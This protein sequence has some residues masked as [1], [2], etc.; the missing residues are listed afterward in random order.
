MINTNLLGAL[1]PGLA[2]FTR[3]IVLSSVVGCNLGESAVVRRS[4]DV[5][6][7]AGGSTGQDALGADLPEP[8]AALLNVATF[9][10][11]RGSGD[12]PEIDGKGVESGMETGMETGSTAADATDFRSDSRFDAVGVF[13][14]A[15]SDADEPCSAEGYQ[16]CDGFEDGAPLWV[17]TGG[18]WNVTEE[19]NA[20]GTNAVFGPTTA[21][22]GIASVPSG[23]WQDMTAE[24]KVMVTSF[25]QPSS[26]N[27]V[28]LYAR[29]QDITH[30][31]AVGL[32]G[33]GKLVLR[34]NGTAFGTLASV[35]VAENEW[36]VL[37]IRLVGASDN[38]VIEGYLDGTLLTAATDTSSSLNGDL[39]TVGVG[40]YG[41]ALA[42]FD[43][44]K[45]SSP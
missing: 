7:G 17:W 37:K 16:F 22:A 8:D 4:P 30:F 27:R 43:N 32:S 5:G 11:A 3:V 36:H 33:D 20:Q 6:Y 24:A 10:G 41:G 21:V 1:S 35:S 42:V 15:A 13:G 26:S 19:S 14:E 18:V 40:V 29:Y 31:Y 12:V 28:L 39:G 44:V 34:R 2:A 25:G 45:V 9:D 38:V 23:A